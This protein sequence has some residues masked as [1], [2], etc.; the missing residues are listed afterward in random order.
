MME[1]KV[2][3]LSAGTAMRMVAE[4]V[5]VG[6]RL[7]YRRLF[8]GEVVEERPIEPEVAGQLFSGLVEQGWH[9]E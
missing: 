2:W 8:E 3:V 9:T 7:L 4:V 1:K 5:Q 6:D